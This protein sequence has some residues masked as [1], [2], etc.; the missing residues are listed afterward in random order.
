MTS[1]YIWVLIFF[2]FP[3]LAYSQTA[4]EYYNMGSEKTAA[5]NYQGAIKDFDQAIGLD[6]K[7]TDAWFNRGTSK[8]Y[9]RDYKEAIADFDKALELRPGFIKALTNRAIAELKTFDT[10]AAISDFDAI[11]KID[12]QNTS[13]WFL[14]GQTELQL[15]DTKTGCSDLTKAYD[16][17]DTRAK[18]FLA[19]NCGRKDLVEVEN[20]SNEYL[21]LDWPDNEGWKIASNQEDKER[22]MIELLR[23][24]ETFENWTEIGELVV[25]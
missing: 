13:A 14:R 24:N 15:G 12:T 2:L 11:L 25:A 10:K 21:K 22:K 1:K 4:Q 23:N 6:A 5:R 17:G 16:L 3:F 18:K 19:Q 9:L 8:L 20:K 7:F